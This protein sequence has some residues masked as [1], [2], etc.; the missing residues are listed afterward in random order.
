M[1][2]GAFSGRQVTMRKPVRK[3][4]LEQLIVSSSLQQIYLLESHPVNFAGVYIM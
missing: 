4:M 1:D 3:A 2:R